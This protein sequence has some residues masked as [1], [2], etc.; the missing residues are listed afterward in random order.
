MQAPTPEFALLSEIH[1]NTRYNDTKQFLQDFQE[2]TKT[3]VR[4]KTECLI[5]G[6]FNLNLLKHDT[7]SDTGCFLNGLLHDSFVPLITRPTRFSDTASSL[8]DN[9]FS[10]KLFNNSVSGTLITD[11]SDHLPIFYIKYE[12][13]FQEIQ[14]TVTYCKRNITERQVND[15][16]LKL[17]QVDWSEVTE[18]S[19]A[20]NAYNA[21]LTK[22]TTYYNKHLPVQCK[23]VKCRNHSYKPWKIPC[24]LKSIRKKNKLYKKF[25]DNRCKETLDRYKL[26]KNKLTAIIRKAEKLYYSNKFSQAAGNLSRTWQI[27]KNLI[28]PNQ[29]GKAVSEIKIGDDIISDSHTIANKFNDYFVNIGPQLA[30]KD[31]I[32][33]W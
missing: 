21:F 10:N 29:T 11:I 15:F 2:I 18:C 13:H 33:G 22:F 28:N 24:I 5:A 6:D 7:H 9:I 26:Y 3:L 27:I 17:A 31:P 20:N 25:L 16:K 1:S 30:K 14:K 32:C 23:T 19:N 12:T 8:I 4:K